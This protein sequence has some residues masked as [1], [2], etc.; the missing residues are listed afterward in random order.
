MF[1]LNSVLSAA[2]YAAGHMKKQLSSMPSAATVEYARLHKAYTLEVSLAN[3]Q[4]HGSEFWKP[5]IYGIIEPYRQ[6]WY[7]HDL[8]TYS[9]VL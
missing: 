8:Q 6:C 4:L 1:Q 7:M 2:R 9:Y 5:Y 3:L